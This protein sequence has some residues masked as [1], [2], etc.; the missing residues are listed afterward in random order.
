MSSAG[1]SRQFH[2][3]SWKGD[4]KGDVDPRAA[5]RVRRVLGTIAALC[6]LAWFAWL[7]WPRPVARTYV[8]CAAVDDYD[9]LQAP[10]LP[11][12]V[13]TIREFKPLEERS[14]VSL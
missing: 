3:Q 6:L 7:L 8:L 9:V 11:F 4:G 10:P 14:G 12:A 5:R 2:R 1:K 13:E